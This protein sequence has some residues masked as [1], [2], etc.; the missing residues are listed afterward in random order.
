MEIT[1]VVPRRRRRRP[2]TPLDP[3]DMQGAVLG[4]ADPEVPPLQTPVGAA[5][6]VGTE[7]PSPFS[8]LLLPPR[9]ARGLHAHVPVTEPL[10]SGRARLR[11]RVAVAVVQAAPAQRGARVAAEA[12]A[13]TPL[14][15]APPVLLAAPA[16]VA[17]LAPPFGLG[18]ARRP[19][20]RVPLAEGRPVLHQP[21]LV[22]RVLARLVGEA[23]VLRAVPPAALVL[24]LLAVRVSAAVLVVGERVGSSLTWTRGRMDHERDGE[25]GTHG[26]CST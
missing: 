16:G 4:P 2:G 20:A 9:A 5:L 17:P 18:R 11:A 21:R 12:R 23:A 7:P 19:L 10:A 15:R 25:K 26:H 6:V 1:P 14:G 8:H 3:T 22:A 13:R 24:G